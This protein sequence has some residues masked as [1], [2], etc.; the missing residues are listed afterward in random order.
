MLRLDNAIHWINHYL[1]DKCEQNKPRYPLDSDLSGRWLYPAFEQ[2][3]PGQFSA[4]LSL[5]CHV[6]FSTLV[7]QCTISASRKSGRALDH[8]K[9]VKVHGVK[10]YAR[11]LKHYK[12]AL[13]QPSS[14][15]EIATRWTERTDFLIIVSTDFQ[16][17]VS[18][19]NKCS[20]GTAWFSGPISGQGGLERL[21]V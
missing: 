14:M 7:S 18:F 21:V 16:I 13:S 12:R 2:P 15:N 20:R 17:T 9:R 8:D 10:G 5:L 6:P 3:G 1:A 19:T 4:P 11:G